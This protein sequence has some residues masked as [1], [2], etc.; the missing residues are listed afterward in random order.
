MVTATI[1]NLSQS[2]LGLVSVHTRLLQLDLEEEKERIVRLFIFLA[3]M[4]IS[5]LLLVV[6]VS[7][8]IAQFFWSASPFYTMMGLALFY[9]FWVVFFGIKLSHTVNKKISYASLSELEKCLSLLSGHFG[10]KD[11]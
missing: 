7:V 3:A 4:M 8:L 11:E 1:K 9:L 2:I 10:E 5:I 6:A